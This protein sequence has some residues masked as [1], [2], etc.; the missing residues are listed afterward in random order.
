[1]QKMLRY[2]MFVSLG[3]N[4]VLGLYSVPHLV[5][6]LKSKGK[7]QQAPAM[8]PL[9]VKVATA[10]QEALNA[11]KEFAGHTKA[12]RSVMVVSNAAGRVK[13]ISFRAGDHVVKGQILLHLDDE[14]ERAEYNKAKAIYEAR[15]SQ[16]ARL[17]K[18]AAWRGRQ[19]VENAILETQ[20][21][22]A[23]LEQ[24]SVNLERTR[25]RAPFDGDIGLI[26]SNISEGAYIDPRQE[27]AR[28]VSS[29]QMVVEFQ[30]T[31]ADA[32]FI[33]V[34]QSVDVTIR[35]QDILPMAAKITA[36]DPFSNTLSHT[37]G[38]Q[39]LIDNS[40]KKFRDGAYTTISIPMVSSDQ[41][42]VVPTDAILNEADKQFAFVMTND[43]VRK[44]E[45]VLGMKNNERVQI[46]SGI[47]GGDIVVTDP[48]NLLFDG[49]PVRIHQ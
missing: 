29:D 20:N 16:R 4:V 47:N 3:L 10:R 36:K 6:S 45:V 35:A 49:R 33:S 17:E 15:K 43:R 11:F 30:V 40:K 14:L 31:E 12:L 1:M 5:E 26:Q 27:I 18:I 32:Q 23:I 34:G 19:D 41:A 38:V 28:V 22:K 46:E 21:A 48:L 7:T 39:A 44:V 9:L 8:K 25:I 13:K 24:A 37:V 2:A 42:I